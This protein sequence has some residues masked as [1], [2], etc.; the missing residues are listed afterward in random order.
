MATTLEIFSS[1]SNLNLGA[2]IYYINQTPPP[3]NVLATHSN[4]SLHVWKQ[5]FLLAL[6]LAL[7]GVPNKA[8]RQQSKHTQQTEVVKRQARPAAAELHAGLERPSQ[9]GAGQ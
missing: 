9:R 3:L 2:V 8:E 6:S 1:R 5:C 4:L 7:C